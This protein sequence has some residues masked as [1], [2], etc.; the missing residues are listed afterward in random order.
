MLYEVITLERKGSVKL[1]GFMKSIDEILISVYDGFQ[2]GGDR[3]DTGYR[4]RP[5]SP[6]RGDPA[7]AA[8][9]LAAAASLL[10]R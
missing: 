1:E 5:T 8:V 7:L 9:A 6:R 4:G 10:I 3:A 2:S